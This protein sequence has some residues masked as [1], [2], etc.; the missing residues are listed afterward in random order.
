[1]ERWLLAESYLFEGA[2]LAHATGGAK[3]FQK[4]LKTLRR[5]QRAPTREEMLVLYPSL[6]GWLEALPPEAGLR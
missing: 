3:S 2:S 1:M 4:L 6:A 5:E